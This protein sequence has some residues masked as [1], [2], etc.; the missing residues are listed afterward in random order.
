MT[1]EDSTLAAKPGSDPSQEL[2][3]SD[4]F[5]RLLSLVMLI[6]VA[7]AIWLMWQLTPRSVATDLVHR[8]PPRPVSMQDSKDIGAVSP[9]LGLSGV[10]GESAVQ[11]P[12]ELQQGEPV[13]LRLSTD[14]KVP[15]A[16]GVPAGSS[17]PAAEAKGAG[18][19]A[20]GAK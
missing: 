1:E 8:V 20:P 17:P 2:I 18:S 10:Q 14:L 12:P 16:P 19:P 9:V 3:G 7:W 5:W 13:G 15:A 6:T 11:T 4:F